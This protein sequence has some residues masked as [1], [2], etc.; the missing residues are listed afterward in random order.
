MSKRRKKTRGNP[1]KHRP[2]RIPVPGAYDEFLGF[3][4]TTAENGIDDARQSLLDAGAT[5][6]QIDR[7]MRVHRCRIAYEALEIGDVDLFEW[8]V[9]PV[10]N[11]LEMRQLIEKAEDLG[12]PKI[13]EESHEH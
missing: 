6:E 1:A 9:A 4:R 7:L 5:D 12:M 3:M 11:E 13:D 8:L 10:A 2:N